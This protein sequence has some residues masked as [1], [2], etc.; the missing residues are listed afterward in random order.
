ML[1]MANSRRTGVTSD[2]VSRGRYEKLRTDSGVAELEAVL[3]CK[4]IRRL[5][6]LIS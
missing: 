5:A 2:H 4:A 1:G 6:S 3:C